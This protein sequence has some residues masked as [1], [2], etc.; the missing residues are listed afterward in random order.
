MVRSEKSKLKR[1]DF[2]KKRV[3]NSSKNSAK[4]TKIFYLYPSQKSDKKYDIILPFGKTVSF[5]AKGYSDYTIH[6]DSQRMQR[7]IIRH[8]KKEDWTSSG[9]RSAG[10]WSRWLLWNKPSLSSSIRNVEKK[11]GIKIITKRN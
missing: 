6:K 8:Q 5:G 2:S 9:F 3:I 1:S 11:F 4:T 10:F 7:Y